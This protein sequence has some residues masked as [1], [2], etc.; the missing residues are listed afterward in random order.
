MRGRGGC[1]RRKL[2]WWVG[3][4]DRH[5]RRIR[6]RLEPERAHRRGDGSRIEYD[7]RRGYR[8]QS[9]LAG[10]SSVE[11]PVGPEYSQARRDQSE[12]DRHAR[13]QRPE[14]HAE[15][16]S[17]DDLPGGLGGEG[18]S[19]EELHGR[20]QARAACRAPRLRQALGLRRGQSD[21]TGAGRGCPRSEKPLA[22]VSPAA[23]V[24]D[25]IEMRLRT[26]VCAGKLTLAQARRQISR[27]KYTQG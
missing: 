19:A 12:P 15:D 9:E 10:D 24:V 6:R 4:R 26:L 5:E 2:G 17:D 25:R 21:P 14:S 20:A 23:V 1:A 7:V 8:K 16:H 22:R 3:R 18:T 13:R 27:I 11:Q